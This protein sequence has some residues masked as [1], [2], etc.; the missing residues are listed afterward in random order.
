VPRCKATLSPIH[1]FH[2][3][4]AAFSGQP[5]GAGGA[6]RF[7]NPKGKKP[8]SLND[9]LRKQKNEKE[10]DQKILNANLQESQKPT[11]P[12]IFQAAK[13][14]Q[15]IEGYDS[16]SSDAAS[17]PILAMHHIFPKDHIL[18]EMRQLNLEDQQSLL[19]ELPSEVLDCIHKAMD[20]QMYESYDEAVAAALYYDPRNIRLGPKCRMFDPADKKAVSRAEFQ[21]EFPAF[22][23]NEID[24][25]LVPRDLRNTF[26]QRMEAC[27][28]NLLERIRALTQMEIGQPLWTKGE[29]EKRLRNNGPPYYAYVVRDFMPLSEEI[30][31]DYLGGRFY[32]SD[33]RFNVNNGKVS[34]HRR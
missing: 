19:R 24:Y 31:K 16:S 27:N 9:I 12:N 15:L 6:A 2:V 14:T 25:E 7:G 23:Q 29:G 18:A 21:A 32:R 30:K 34:R 13:A 3:E 22:M 5:V 11:I 33:L 8:N 28:G 26:A 17:R 4:E 20:A 10:K 1:A